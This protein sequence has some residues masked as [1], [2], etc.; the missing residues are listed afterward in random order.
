MKDMKKAVNSREYSRKDSGNSERPKQNSEKP[1]KVQGKAVRGL[2]HA[3][4]RIRVVE[5][6]APAATQSAEKE[7]MMSRGG[8]R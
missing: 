6:H 2:W 7:W 5:C 1:V 3:D 4:G 8:G